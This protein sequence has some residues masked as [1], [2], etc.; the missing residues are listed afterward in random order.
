MTSSAHAEAVILKPGRDKPVR[1]RHPW[2]FSGSVHSLPQEAPDGAIVPVHDA[3][4]HWLAYGFLNRASQIQVRL[5][6]WEEDE[7]FDEGFWRNRLQRAINL[8]K[9]WRIQEG[10]NAYRIV[11]AESDYLPGLVVDQYADHLVVQI[12]AL[13]MEAR[14]AEMAALLQELTGCR[15]ITERSDMAARKQ[16][17]LQEVNGPLGSEAPPDYVEVYEYGLKFLVDVIGGQKTGFYTDQ[18]V[19]RHR[20]AAYCSGARVLNAFSYTGAFAVHALHQ[21]AGFVVNVDSSYSAL[22]LAERN[23]RLN[24]FD[25]DVY[26]ENIAGDVFEV[27]RDARAIDSAGQGFDV[28]VIDPPKFVHNRSGLERGLRG[29]KEV[30]MQALRLLKPDGILATFSCSG[31]VDASLFQKVIFGAAL[32]TGR[33]LQILER[34]GQAPDHPVAVT[35]PEAD[36]LSGL[37]CHVT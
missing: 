11:N 2:I 29:Y 7:S 19:N 37:V 15:S 21:D 10:T 23:L 22:E 25:P 30:N 18:R 6:S 24:G 3:G 20:V 1:Q 8:R 9:R 27:L 12:G 36:Y 28:A 16:E 4:G 34:L 31:L 14:K 17:R 32:D 35:F 33:K 13:G 5:L 26:T